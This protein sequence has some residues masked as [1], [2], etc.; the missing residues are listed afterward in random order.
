[1][2]SSNFAF[3][4]SIAESPRKWSLEDGEIPMRICIRQYIA[5]FAEMAKRKCARKRSYLD[6]ETYKNDETHKCR[7]TFPVILSTLK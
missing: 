1:M 3:S 6:G 4:I 2:F 7:V 5:R